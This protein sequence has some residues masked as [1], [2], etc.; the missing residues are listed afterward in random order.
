[1]ALK[2]LFCHSTAPGI[3]TIQ[4]NLLGRPY[5]SLEKPPCRVMPFAT[6]NGSPTADK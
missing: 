4:L 6:I 3:F 1:M 5:K 2:N